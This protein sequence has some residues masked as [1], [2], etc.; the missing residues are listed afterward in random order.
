MGFADYSDYDGVGLAELV[1]K[2]KVKPVEL[3]EAAIERIERHN[4]KLNAVVFKAYDSA[5]ARAKAKLGG[6]FA[7]VPMLLKDILGFK[8]GWPNRSGSRF[9]PAAPAGFD[10]T[11]VTRF[12]TAGLIPLGKT[13]VPEYGLVPLTESKLYGPARNPWN[14][15]HSTGGSSGGSAA[16]V[17][18]GIVPI[19]HANDGGGSIRIPASC[20][21][22]VGLKPTRGR[23]PL[24]PVVGDVMG[25]LLVEHVV[26][27]S[28]RDAAAILDATHGPEIGDPYAAPPPP[29][30]Y[31][32]AIAKKPKKLRIA[33]TGKRLDGTALD[34]ECEA[35]AEAAARLCEKLGHHVE[36][37]M[38]QVSPAVIGAT[39]LP[40]WASILAMLIDFIA[41]ESGQTPAREQIEGLSWGMYQYGRTVLAAQY[42]LNWT[43]LQGLSRHV[44][45]WQQP[46]DAW[47]TPVL[48]Q[49]PIKIGSIN[50][51][52]TDLM[53]AFAPIIGYLPFT[54]LQ[55]ITG[56]P[57]ISLPL[58]WSKSGLP[59]GLQFVGRFGEEH[60]LLALAAQL[61]KAQP[62]SKRRPQVYG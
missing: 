2:K 17:A 34:P 33:F 5:R 35:A 61:E 42:Q 7:G 46:Y 40:I 49:P 25:G 28:V 44:A 53:K 13:N 36:E 31:L 23:N 50:L 48:S 4:S 12:E 32:K 27:R 24:G 52:E 26:C 39:F 8:K 11:L 54:V 47:I 29:G 60:V 37:A 43:M 21:G 18:A 45:R 41:K 38:P 59:I 55:N 62:W 3:V 14:L 15:D 1:R 57:A 30:P 58:A 20:C 6:A 56:Q 19:A 16:A 22:L 9:A 10:S 51:E